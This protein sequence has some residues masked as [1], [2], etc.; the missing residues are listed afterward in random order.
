MRS[1]LFILLIFAIILS[2]G[3]ISAEIMLSQPK[4]IYSIGDFLEISATVKANQNIDNLFTLSLKCNDKS[5]DFYLSPLSLTTGQQEKI[6][7]KVLLSS[8]FLRDMKGDCRIESKFGG[9]TASS[10]AFQITNR[11]ETILNVNPLNAK[12]GESI[13]IKGTATKA[14][15]QLLEG[16][17]EISIAETDIKLTGIVSKG[18]FQIN[19]SFPENLKSGNYILKVKVY[20]KS[21]GEIGNFDEKTLSLNM[22]QEPNKIEIVV[23]K[24]SVRPGEKIKFKPLIYDQANQE[25]QG[26][27]KIEIK[28]NYDETYLSKLVKTNEEV[29]IALESNASSGYWK[30]EASSFDLKA[31]R[32][33]YI[34]E[35]QKAKFE[36]INNTLIITNIGNVPY[37]KAVQ[38]TIGN[39]LEIKEL[40]LNLGESKRFRLIAPDG[41]YKVSVADGQETLTLNDI[42]LT[43]NVIGVEDIRNQLSLFNRYPIVW[44]FLIIVFGLFILMMVERVA[45]RKFYRYASEKKETIKKEFGKS[46]EA[47]KDFSIVKDIKQ[48]E[49]SLV[50]SGKKEEASIMALKIKNPGAMKNKIAAESIEKVADK[51]SRH[52]G[53]LYKAGD[54]LIGIFTPSLT[55]TF[56]NDLTS[57]KV[58]SE[59]ASHLNEHNRKFKEKIDFG[60]GIH[61]GDI[62]VKL[63]NEKLKFTSL[64]NTI[65]LAKRISEKAENDVL[66]SKESSSKVSGEVKTEKSG[67][68]YSIKR[69]VDREQH[70]NFIDSFLKRN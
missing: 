51:I 33:F 64:G 60:I 65:N 31:I 20:D 25:I 22:A 17:V 59:I 11:I 10:P 28:D 38:I 61:S 34:E 66:L 50:L 37:R 36:I 63:E 47:K 57:V 42:G 69:I 44:L 16:Y 43:G 26:D 35:L 39:E 54:N 49:H 53:S 4:S 19:F 41:N 40:D 30:I 56:R 52:K 23:D 21:D 68:Y 48:A 3:I 15:S 27:I 9:E 14:N 5:N 13:N 2:L 12:P 8:S 1:K 32:L 45:K 67:D 6:E 18:N 7:K 62:A 24:Q 46:E 29:E 58:A 55:K 70:K